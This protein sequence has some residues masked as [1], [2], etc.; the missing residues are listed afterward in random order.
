MQTTPGQIALNRLLPEDLRQPSHHINKKSIKKLLQQVADKYPDRFRDIAQEVMQLGHFSSQSSGNSLSLQSM[1]PSPE[2]EAELKALRSKVREI[3]ESDID[4]ATQDKEIIKLVSEAS[5]K[6]RED[7][8]ER[9]KKAGN[10]LALQ[11]ESGSRGNANQLASLVIGDM[12]VQDHRDE[13]IS[14]PILHGYAEGVEPAE[15]F[16]GSYGARKGV[17][18]LKDATPKA[19]FLG[20]QLA[21]SSHRQ[22]VTMKD[23]GTSNG[24]T[25]DTSEADNVGAVPARSVEGVNHDKPLS[26]RDLKSYDKDNITL[27]S[28]MTCEAP[29]GICSKCAGVRESGKLPEI[30]DNVGISS[31][32]SVSEKVSQM[33]ISSKH[34]GGVAGAGGPSKGGF[35][36]INQ[37]VQVPRNFKDAAPLA[38]SDGTITNIR[39]APQGGKYVSIGETQHYV[40]PGQDVTVNP[41]QNVEAGDTL[42]NGIP[43]PAEV[44][45]HKGIGEGRKYFLNA[46]KEALDASGQ[47]V[48]RRN[49]E[50]LSRSL[51]S[52]VRVTNDDGYGGYLPD[53]VVPYEQFRSHYEP[54]EGSSAQKP[55]DAVGR[56]LERPSSHFSLGTRVTPSVAKK[57]EQEG[58]MEVQT[59]EDPPPFEPHMVRAM[60]QTS[61]DPNWITRMSGSYLQKGFLDALHRGSSA[62]L[63]DT[64]YV[65]GLAQAKDF[66]KDLKTTG[67]Y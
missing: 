19:G 65:P 42:S 10:P 66:G 36:R 30:G 62:D 44:A 64:S 14:T 23:C 4:D 16:A 26:S 56:Y 7:L 39:E 8:F 9:E 38:E 34:S 6:L 59:H 37:L 21:Q 29:E 32:Q 54:R 46:F 18:D 60:E 58:M 13:V 45:K 28:P 63:Q 31:A 27:R 40:H 22:V 11:A 47:K 43:N 24:I 2:V 15:F 51:V 57:L 5:P 49:L 67:R 25:A 48:H 33:T 3:T 12:L 55:R 61:M 1:I 53:D 52:H 17:V 41:G 35:D 50:T 20:K